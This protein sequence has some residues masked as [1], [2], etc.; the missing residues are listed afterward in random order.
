MG[1][2]TLPRLHDTFAGN[3]VQTATQSQVPKMPMEC[4]TASTYLVIVLVQG[5]SH[6]PGEGRAQERHCKLEL[7]SN[8]DDG[9]C[10]ASG[11]S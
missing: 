1:A 9:M 6:S 10:G 5:G 3:C 4:G 2:V 7:H 11:T 8:E